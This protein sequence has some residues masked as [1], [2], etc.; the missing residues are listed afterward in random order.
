MS[1]QILTIAHYTAIRMTRRLI[2]D[3][4]PEI[5]AATTDDI[6]SVLK[7]LSYRLREIFKLR[8]G[9]P[10]GLCYSVEEVGYIFKISSSRVSQLHKRG[11]TEFLKRIAQ[12]LPESQIEPIV[13]RSVIETATEL[14]PYL[15][16]H[17]KDSPGDLRLLNWR[18]F[19]HLVAEFFSASG[20]DDV[21]LVGRSG[22]TAA[23]VF[24]MRKIEPD[25]TEVRIF[26]ET[27][28]WKDRVGVE[29][30][31][32]V[33]GAFIAEKSTFGWHMAMIV[34]V[35]GFT[36]MEKYT[37]EKLRMMGISLKGGE[38][39]KRWLENYRFSESG[40]WLPDHTVM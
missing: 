25:G 39:V 3:R 16:A 8:T 7:T 28:R 19:E 18:V 17:L 29:V 2:G 32:R 1:D 10:D 31:D 38:D 34:T 27:K 40:L 9:Y 15:I 33:Y 12:F 30:I 20:F 14:T 6:D 13:V 22:K 24:A 21:R 36:E 23:D 4:I 37:P 26:I 35:A 5:Q 11:R